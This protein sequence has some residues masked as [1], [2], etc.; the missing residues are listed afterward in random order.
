M[1]TSRPSGR[2]ANTVD[3]LQQRS[4]GKSR[5]AERCNTSGHTSESATR[6]SASAP[7][8]SR[9]GRGRTVVA[10]QSVDVHSRL[11]PARGSSSDERRLGP[12]RIGDDACQRIGTTTP[13][14][15]I[16]RRSGHT[17]GTAGEQNDVPQ[18]PRQRRDH[19]SATVSTSCQRKSDLRRSLSFQ[20][21]SSRRRFDARITTV[22]NGIKYVDV[23]VSDCFDSP[24]GVTTTVSAGGNAYDSPVLVT[25]R[26]HRMRG[27]G[28]IRE[29]RHLTVQFTKRL[30]TAPRALPPSS[31][32]RA[33]C[34]EP[35]VGTNQFGP[36]TGGS[37]WSPRASPILGQPAKTDSPDP[38]RTDRS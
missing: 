14:S 11:P 31:Q 32:P 1:P 25:G 21:G 23:A 37:R 22:G 33:E 29:R 16:C 12:D 13:P 24:T 6:A 10:G 20:N 27:R 34:V 4:T 15:G 17:A 35:A 36:E 28:T 19:P 30:R 26:L 3:D 2:L 5:R 38:S 9:R 8:R 18:V 7:R